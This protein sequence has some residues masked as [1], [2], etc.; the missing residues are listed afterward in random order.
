[1]LDWYTLFIRAAPSDLLVSCHKLIDFIIVTASRDYKSRR[2]SIEHSIGSS[3]RLLMLNVVLLKRSDQP[4]FGTNTSIVF[5]VI[6]KD[7]LGGVGFK[8]GIQYVIVLIVEIELAPVEICLLK[9]Y[10][11]SDLRPIASGF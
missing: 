5:K 4:S 1:M 7:R 3:D 8:T 10:L 6:D 11:F 2:C 9:S